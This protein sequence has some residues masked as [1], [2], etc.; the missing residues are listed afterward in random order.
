[1]INAARIRDLLEEELKQRNLFLVEVSVRPGN[2]LVVYIDNM[3]GVTLE[4]CMSVSR[5]LESK[6]DRSVEDYELEVSSPGLDKPL[7][8]PVQYEKNIGRVLDVVKNDG[9]KITGKLLGLAGDTVRL[10]TERIVRDNKT[11]KKKSEI[12]IQEIRL[13]EIKTAKIIISVKK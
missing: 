6:L 9:I 11:H 7:K 10:E 3:E 1:M 13:D 5:F 12:I 2:I 8:L 4:A